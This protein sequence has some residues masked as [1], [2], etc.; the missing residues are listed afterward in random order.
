MKVNN[1]IRS[2]RIQFVRWNWQSKLRKQA[3]TLELIIT[4]LGIVCSLCWCKNLNEIWE[5]HWENLIWLKGWRPNMVNKNIWRGESKHQLR[6]F[7]NKF[8]ST[9]YSLWWLMQNMLYIKI[10]ISYPLD[11]NLVTI[12]QQVLL[13]KVQ[14]IALF[15]G[16]TETVRVK[17]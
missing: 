17:I 8:E 4:P 5:A 9:I 12:Y 1:N 6:N 14:G 10:S 7:P 15:R 16:H 13:M 2:W 11:E 3:Q